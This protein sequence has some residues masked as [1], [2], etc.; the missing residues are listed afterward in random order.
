LAALLL[1]AAGAQANASVQDAMKSVPPQSADAMERLRFLDGVWH[2]QQYT[3]S[4]NLGS[5]P[6]DVAYTFLPGGYWLRE[7]T[8]FPPDSATRSSLWNHALYIGHDDEYS[9][10]PGFSDAPFEVY[11]AGDRDGVPGAGGYSYAGWVGKEFKIFDQ[12]GG[13]VTLK[14]TGANSIEWQYEP[15]PDPHLAYYPNRLRKCTR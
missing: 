4:P 15:K 3:S 7:D 2:C 9:K 5:M 1:G 10:R 12:W 11:V 13:V 8:T 6:E 14:K